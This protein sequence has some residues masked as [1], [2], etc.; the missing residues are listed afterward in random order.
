MNGETAG[1]WVERGPEQD[2]GQGMPKKTPR[3]RPLSG[4]GQGKMSWGCAFGAAAAL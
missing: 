1:V 4:A 3:S 2:Q